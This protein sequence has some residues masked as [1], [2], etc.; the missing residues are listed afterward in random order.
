MEVMG[1]VVKAPEAKMVWLA[2][3]ALS[4]RHRPGALG[5]EP[6]VMI[7]GLGGSSL[8]WTELMAGLSDRLDCSA[9]D[10][11][12]FGESPPPRD[13]DFS[14]LGQAR[15]VAELIQ[16]RHSEPVHLFGNSLG[17]A[18]ALQLAA[19]YPELIRS[20]TLISPALPRLLPTRETMHMPIIA[21]PG[22]GDRLLKRYGRVDAEQRVQSTFELTCED[23]SRVHPQRMVDALA[24]VRARDSLSY[25]S[26]V[27]RQSLRG[28]IATYLERGPE[29]P[30]KLAE[31][32]TVPTLL[33]YGRVD[34]VVNSVAAHRAT[35]HF[36][37]A[38][39][40]TIPDSGHVA[41]IEHPELVERS[42]RH[43][44]S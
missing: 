4:V 11:A 24:E 25:V 32:I 33:I 18:V 20:L 22:V 6:A 34:R 10:L 41:Q 27:Y 17:G 9:V 19:R 40:V 38:H 13:G 15:G 8:N 23:S 43:F 35:R 7:H 16:E 26:D 2:Q 36:P 5:A 14:P 28:L 31:S 29:R 21:L 44:I 3:R 37:N 30:W 42:W 39:V 12:G 1:T